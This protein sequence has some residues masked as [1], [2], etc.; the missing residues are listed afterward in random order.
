M[1]SMGRNWRLAAAVVCAITLAAC[2][3]WAWGVLRQ[4]GDVSDSRKTDTVSAS[5]MARNRGR[6]L[7]FERLARTW[8]ID[9]GM[10]ADDLK[11]LDAAALAS[12]L[13]TPAQSTPSGLAGLLSEGLELDAGDG[14]GPEAGSMPC[15]QRVIATCQLHPTSQDWWGSELYGAGAAW[16]DGPTVESS[17]GRTVRV[18]GTVRLMAVSDGDTYTQGGWRALTPAWRDYRVD[19]VLTFDGAGRISNVRHRAQDHWWID[20]W[21]TKWDE[22]LI[23]DLNA[24]DTERTA[25][26]VAGLPDMGM[27]QHTSLGGALRAPSSMGDMSGVDWSLWTGVLNPGGDAAGQRQDGLDPQGDADT[28]RQRMLDAGVSEGD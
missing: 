11:G 24:S 7:E 12:R 18:A 23:A 6:A 15:R 4:H 1:G 5:E 13:R 26:P 22:N 8:G 21:L 10:G 28:L 17:D 3:W 20:P 14:V 19:D 9:A 27:L 25:I 16:K 2:A